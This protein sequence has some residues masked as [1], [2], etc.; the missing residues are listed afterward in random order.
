MKLSR[1]EKKRTC[2][3]KRSRW[4]RGVR[5]TREIAANMRIMTD[6]ALLPDD[7]T[8]PALVQIKKQIAVTLIANIAESIA[9]FAR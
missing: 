9:V 4:K 1:K 8:N 7:P 5:F 2:G 3:T 6:L